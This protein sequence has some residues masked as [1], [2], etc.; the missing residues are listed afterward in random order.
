VIKR[1][2]WF[3][4]SAERLI[5]EGAGDLIKNVVAQV[6]FAVDKLTAGTLLLT[7]VKRGS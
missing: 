1:F 3:W 7:R 6:C 2:L 5:A 4:C